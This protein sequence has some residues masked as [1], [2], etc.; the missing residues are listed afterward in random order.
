MGR[1]DDVVPLTL[2]VMVQWICTPQVSGLSSG[3]YGTLSSELLT[4]NYDIS[5]IKLSVRWCVWKDFP[6]GSDPRH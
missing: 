2:F 4:D 5:I 3:G 6:I 1:H